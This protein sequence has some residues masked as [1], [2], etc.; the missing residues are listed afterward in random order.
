M[1]LKKEE[2]IKREKKIEEKKEEKGERRI[3]IWCSW[4]RFGLLLA[5]LKSLNGAL[6]WGMYK[7]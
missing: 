3:Q 1:G 7:T 5:S 4:G 6:N 2:E